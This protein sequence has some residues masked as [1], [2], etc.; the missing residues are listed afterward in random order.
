LNDDDLK[1][2]IDDPAMRRTVSAVEVVEAVLARI[3][4]DGDRLAAFIT[5]TPEAALAQARAVDQRRTREGRAGALDGLPIAIKDNIDVAGVRCTAGSAWF[6][7]RVATSDAEVTRLLR[8]AGAVIVAKTNMHELAYGA[9][10]V[11]PHFGACRNPWDVTR[12]PGGSSGGSG[13][14]LG[15]D[16]CF[17]ALGTDTG[18][19]VRI[20]A[21]LNGVTAL[22]PT[23]GSVSNRGV[24]PISP[25]LDTVGTMARSA[26]DVAVL[27]RVIAG[28]DLRD[29]YAVAPPAGAARLRPA[30]ATGN[31]GRPLDG[32][33]VGVARGFFFANVADSVA[34]NALAAA[35]VLS[36]LGTSTTEIDTS[37]AE[38][39]RDD[40]AELIRAEALALH[41]DRLRERGD[42]IGADVRE[43]FELG[44]DSTG[45]QVARA[46]DRMRRW[47]ARM[48]EAFVEV[49]V[50]LTP[51]TPDVAPRIDDGHM[52]ALTAELTRLTYPWSLG[53][54]PAISFPSGLDGQGLPTGVQLAAAPW[55]DGLLL[56]VAREFQRVT[57][58]HLQRPPAVYPAGAR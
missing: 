46:L 15:A 32:L 24:L 45:V 48:R 53:W 10:T 11:N 31:S 56:D 51:T 23:Y 39:A 20:P 5:V 57:S 30:Q 33:R 27:A 36:D 42:E 50:I 38:R 41:E 17:A 1:A 49:D 47:Q 28:Y 22:R 54:L 40:A 29:P 4:R 13:A 35:D 44:R 25:S 9:T 16:L 52:I 12:V 2:L 34:T 14:A 37:G 18:G 55:R 6:A 8:Q 3:A 26:V 7:E 19:S 58:F 43:R 21:A